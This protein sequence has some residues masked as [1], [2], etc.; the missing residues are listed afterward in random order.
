MSLEPIAFSIYSIQVCGFKE[1]RT[2][3]EEHNKVFFVWLESFSRSDQWLEWETVLKE[4]LDP[5]TSGKKS[6]E[7]FVA[8]GYFVRA[9]VCVCECVCVRERE[10]ERCWLKKISTGSSTFCQSKFSVDF[11]SRAFPIFPSFFYLSNDRQNCG[12]RKKGW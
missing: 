3:F 12:R 6:S 11:F 4:L 2:F 8:L 10:N 9:C 5:L 1:K 7:F